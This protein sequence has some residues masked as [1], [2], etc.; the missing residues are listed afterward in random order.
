MCLISPNLSF[1]RNQK[2]IFS[3]KKFKIHPLTTFNTRVCLQS[4]SLSYKNRIC[5]MWCC[6][7][8][9]W[10]F[11]N[12]TDTTYLFHYIWEKENIYSRYF[13]NSHQY[14]LDEWIA[15]GE[16][17]QMHV[18]DFEVNWPFNFRESLLNVAH[19]TKRSITFS[20]SRTEDVASVADFKDFRLLRNMSKE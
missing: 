15:L 1:P 20:Q 12:N 7:V 5:L 9:L 19:F 11:R 13:Q 16:R 4:L 8:I 2:H 6:D 14:S 18:V 17:G 10:S 3:N